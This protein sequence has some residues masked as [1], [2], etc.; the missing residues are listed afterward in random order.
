MAILSNESLLSEMIGKTMVSAT[1]KDEGLEV[2]FLF[3]DDTKY[4]FGHDQDC[5]EKV[6]LEDIDGELI[7]LIGS[8]LLG[9]EEVTNVPEPALQADEYESFTWTFYKLH[10]QKGYVTLRFYG[11]SNG[12]YSERVDI[13]KT[14]GVGVQ[15]PCQPPD[16]ITVD[17]ITYRRE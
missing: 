1:V 10:T 11:A 17:G 13:Y 14:E 7:D 16:T 5:C 4:T 15:K 8:P 2:I 12:Y 6:Y 3:D 9:A